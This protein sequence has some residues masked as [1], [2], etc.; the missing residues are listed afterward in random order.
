[1]YLSLQ[2]KHNPFSR[3]FYIS[4]NE[5]FFTAGCA[6]ILELELTVD[7]VL[8]PHDVFGLYFDVSAYGLL[9]EW[10]NSSSLIRANSMV[11]RSVHSLNFWTLAEMSAFNPPKKVP[12]NAFCGQPTTRLANFSNSF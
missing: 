2:L 6:E 9:F 12:I 11:S 3:L 5:I 1:M 10:A 7:V 8:L 4:S